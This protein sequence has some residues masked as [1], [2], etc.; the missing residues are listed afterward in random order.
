MASAPSAVPTLAS[1]RRGKRRL[2]IGIVVAMVALALAGL[3]YARYNGPVNTV[4]GYF[5]DAFVTFDAQSAAG[6]ICSDSPQKIKS[7]ADFQ[8]Q[9]DLVKGDATIDLS[10]IT[11]TMTS[12]NLISDATVHVGGTF[13]AAVH[14]LPSVSVP[15]N[16]DATLKSSGLGWC[17]ESG[18][19]GPASPTP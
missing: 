14:G 5:Q 9:L 4:K 1:A 18:P 6:R 15:L 2:I 13:K 11:Y 3:G 19:P 17:I 8:Q 10:G 16:V 12:Q 7:I